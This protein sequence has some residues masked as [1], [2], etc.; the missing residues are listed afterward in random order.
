[1]RCYFCKLEV[2]SQSLKIYQGKSFH[3]YCFD[4]LMRLL[5]KKCEH[6]GKQVAHKDRA[7]YKDYVFHEMCL[8]QMRDYLSGDV[9]FSSLH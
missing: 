1:M 7:D 9:Y 6:C 8:K 4:K 5:R 2:P 3:D